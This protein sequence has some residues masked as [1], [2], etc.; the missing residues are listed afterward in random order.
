MKAFANV[1]RLRMLDLRSGALD[2]FK[3]YARRAFVR[4]AFS[5][6]CVSAFGQDAQQRHLVLLGAH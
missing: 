2:A 3:I 4:Y 1:V 6:L 5:A